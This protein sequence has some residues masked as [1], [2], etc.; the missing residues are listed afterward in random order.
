ME[1]KD[2]NVVILKSDNLSITITKDTIQDNLDTFYKVIKCDTIDIVRRKIGKKYYNII[3]DDEG[4]LKEK[5]IALMEK[6]HREILVGNLIIT[7][8]ED[9]NGELTSL[10]EKEQTDIISTFLQKGLIYEI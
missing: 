10:T 7:G 4:L 3:C 6:E 8:L 1:N 9:K 5:S 2:L